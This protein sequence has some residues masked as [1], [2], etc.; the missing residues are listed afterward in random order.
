MFSVNTYVK[1]YVPMPDDAINGCERPITG[2]SS[3]E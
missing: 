2:T 3:K 1:E